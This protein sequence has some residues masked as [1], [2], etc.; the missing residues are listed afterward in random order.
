M[1]EAIGGQL[2]GQHAEAATTVRTKRTG[3]GC[4]CRQIEQ[5]RTA[6]FLGDEQAD[7]ID[8]ERAGG[9]EESVVADFLEAAG[10]QMIQETAEELDGWQT[11][12]AGLARLCVAE[13]ESDH[14]L[15][16]FQDAAVGDG[17]AEDITG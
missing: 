9:A 6:G 2:N 1:L 15:F 16:E 8:R 13:A 11:H 12:P 14:A 10:E 4:G 17:N 7:A 5:H 3:C